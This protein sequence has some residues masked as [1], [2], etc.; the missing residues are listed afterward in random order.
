MAHSALDANAAGVL[1][2]HAAVRDD[3]AAGSR[4]DDAAELDAALQALGH[5]TV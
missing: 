2:V 5:A 1:A 3:N 4:A